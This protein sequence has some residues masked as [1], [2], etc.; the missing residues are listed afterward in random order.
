MPVKVSFR[1][2]PD[3]PLEKIYPEGVHGL[4]FNILSEDLFQELHSSSLKPFSLWSNA[5]FTSRSVRQL[6]LEV[7]LLKRE[8]LSRLL[9]SF[10]LEERELKLGTVKLSKSPRPLVKGNA[11]KSY[12]DLYEEAEPSD[13][14]VFD[15]LTPTSFK[16]GKA[17]HPLPEP[18][19]IFKSLIRKWV[20][21][22]DFPLGVDLRKIIK[23]RTFISGA[24]IKTVK[25]ALSDKARAVGFT[26]RVVLFI[27]TKDQGQRSLK[28]DKRP[29][30]VC[31]VCGRGEKDDDGNG[32]GEAC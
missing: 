5:L 17:D 8:L 9:V 4:F 7:A 32:E 26:G 14:I 31:R 24:W 23:E 12:T 25:F 6:E 21:F 27:D 22:S 2:Y 1:L 11:R 3:G 20:T 15:F 13:T 10:L 29:C 30:P 28:V 19:L 18:E 16:R